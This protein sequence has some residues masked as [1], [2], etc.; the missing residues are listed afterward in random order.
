[1][2][3]SCLLKF[4]PDV[5]NFKY[6]YEKNTLIRENVKLILNPDDASALALALRI[7]KSKP[8]TV[9]EIVSMAS[10]S[11]VPLLEDLLRRNVDKATLISDKDFAGSDTYVTSQVLARYLEKDTSD[12]I[13]TGTHSLD[14][15]TSHIPS[16]VGELLRLRQLSHITRV[17][18]ESL[19]Q[20][21]A[22]VEVDHE[23]TLERYEIDFPCILSISRESRYKLPFVKY[24][25]LHLDVSDRMTILSNEDLR[26]SADEV[27]LDGSLTYV[28][29]TFTRKLE[30]KEKVVVQNDNQGI[31]TVYHYL[32]TRGFV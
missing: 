23:T 6:D 26:F 7:K 21:S 9:I 14:G 29:R 28:N 1:M 11:T 22:I 27:G 30:P 10:R 13:L 12:F 4:I 16:Q 8:D 31:D 20:G 5:E 2:K 25:D 18:E 15:D 24:Q 32:K 3:I 19:E 17:D